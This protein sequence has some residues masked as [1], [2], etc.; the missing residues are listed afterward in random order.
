VSDLADFVTTFSPDFSNPE[1]APKAVSLSERAA[2]QQGVD[3]HRQEALRGQRLHQVPRQRRPRRRP[4]APTLADDVGSPD[5]PG[6]SDA[7][8]DLPRRRLARGHLQDDEHRP[9]RDADAVV[10]RRPEGRSAVGDHRLHRL[11]RPRH[12]RLHQPGHRQARRR[13]DRPRQRGRELRV[14]PRRAL[15]DHRPDHRTGARVPSAGDVR[16]RA[17]DL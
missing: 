1:R 8:L 14:R 10:R 13:S 6:G 9:E 17:G 15:S 11:A 12:A 16:H 7:A 3:R 2:I 5:P 4:V